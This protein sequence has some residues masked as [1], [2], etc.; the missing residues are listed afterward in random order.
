[1]TPAPRAIVYEP[2]ARKRIGFFRTWVV[3]SSNICRSRGLV[4]QLFKRDFLAAYKKSFLGIGW[5]VISPLIGILSWILMNATGVLKPGAVDIPYPAYVL[6]GSAIWGLFMG[7]FT[8]AESTLQSGAGLILQ[9]NFPHEVLL[10]QQTAQHVANF[11]LSFLLSIVVLIAFGVVPSW[12]VIF[13]PVLVL[14][15]FF[16]GAGIGLVVSVFG[17]V[18]IELRRAATI[19][20]G[21]GIYV[22]PIIY[23]PKVESPALQSLIAY[24]PLTYLIGL[25]RDIVIRGHSDL[26]VGYGWSTLL[27]LAI[28]LLSWRLFFVSENK[29]VERMV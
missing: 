14:P 9:V 24:N 1:M 26:W 25:V 5:V 20:L 27:A 29:V 13:L 28:F 15:L 3:M 23:S 19:V 12:K 8:A 16:L 21:L 10:A 18:A 4:Y 22:T 2:H 6:L 7:F 11:C 17:V